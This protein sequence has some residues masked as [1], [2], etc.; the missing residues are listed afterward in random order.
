MGGGGT[1]ADEPP[2]GDPLREVIGEVRAL[3]H[4]V[5]VDA[6]GTSLLVGG[7]GRA[8][9]VA[10]IAN[11]GRTRGIGM[12][13]DS[14]LRYVERRGE[15]GR[16]LGAGAGALGLTGEVVAADLLAVGHGRAPW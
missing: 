7:A 1:T 15:P 14:Y 2:P 16:W 11:G 10:N 4:P 13:L 12:G 8:G 6:I 3:D 9:V 5:D